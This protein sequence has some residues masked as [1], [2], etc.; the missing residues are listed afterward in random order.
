VN[1]LRSLSVRNR[2]LLVGAVPALL[3]VFV[4]TAYHMLN[5][6]WDLR[7]EHNRIARLIV[8]HISASAE[9]PLITGNYDL[10]RPLLTTALS[11]PSIVSLQILDTS[12]KVLVDMKSDNYSRLQP[13]DIVVRQQDMLRKVHSLDEFS[14]FGDG[15]VTVQRLGTIRLG[16]SDVFIRQ[17][18]VSIMQQSLLT[19]LVVVLLAAIIGILASR[20][21]LPPL[22]RLSRF[23]NLL[24]DGRTHERTPVDDGAE[25]GTLQVNVNKLAE[26][27]QKAE[28]DQKEYTEKIISEQQKTQQASRAKSDF[29]AMM[30]HELRTPLN[31]AI[32]M[33]QL[34]DLS[35]SKEEFDDFKETADQ[36]LTHLTQ[37]LE[38]VLVVVDTEKNRLPVVFS[39]HKIA[40]VLRELLESQGRKAKEKNLQ[41]RVSYDVSLSQSALQ[42][43]PSLIRQ[44][45][46]HLVDNAIKFTDQGYVQLDLSLKQ[47]GDGDW[48]AVSVQ[49]TGI[50]IAEDQKQRVLEAFAQVNSSFSRRY[51]GIGLGLTIT[52]HICSL[53]G[54]Q[55]NIISDGNTGTRVE[56]TLPVV[57]VVGTQDA[58]CSKE[59]A[60]RALI[61]EDN[62]VNLKVVEK[63]LARAW[64]S[65]QISSVISGEACLEKTRHEHFDL[66]LMDCQMPGLDGFETTRRLRQS[67]INTPIVACTANTTDQIRERC[68]DAG[69]NDYMAKPVKVPVLKQTLAKWLPGEPDLSV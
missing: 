9:Y 27:L 25:I 54:G 57:R 55:L 45:V 61:V 50:G 38:D 56:A 37:L 47:A 43:D 49:D 53:L 11:Q 40:E 46:R 8:E 42:S 29:L 20:T 16:M 21:I 24:A 39:E 26:S 51:E 13:G 41:F 4:L 66:I 58:G 17:Q 28:Q 48:L 64:E 6:W 19:G 15:E 36:S 35:N 63:M 62:P 59:G 1:G 68:L 2:M 44:V 5:R 14:E 18:E 10:L 7:E 3:A 31:G 30:S 32:G 69:M 22:A 34:M 67:G 23:I 60:L 12:G 65:M 33:L 52:Q